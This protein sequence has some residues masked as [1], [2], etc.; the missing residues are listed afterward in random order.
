MCFTNRSNLVLLLAFVHTRPLRTEIGTALCSPFR[1]ALARG[2]AVK[3]V[4]RVGCCQPPPTR[5]TQRVIARVC[6]EGACERSMVIL[7]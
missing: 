4:L 6:R 1:H 3:T 7:W 2:R 5:A